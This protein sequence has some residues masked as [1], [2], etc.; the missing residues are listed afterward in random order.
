[1]N[2]R[3]AGGN[4]DVRD[5]AAL[6]VEQGYTVEPNKG[7]HLTVRDKEGNY[8]T[9][10]PNSPSDR[11][12]RKNALGLFR[13]TVRERGP[14]EDKED[15]NTMQG[16]KTGLEIPQRQV[17]LSSR[18]FGALKE[19]GWPTTMNARGEFIAEA[20]R[21]ARDMFGV[22][23]SPWGSEGSAQSALTDLLSGKRIVSERGLD[24][25]DYITTA[26]PEETA[27]V[28][29]KQKPRGVAATGRVIEY[30][31]K[32]MLERAIPLTKA[33][34]AE[35]DGRNEAGVRKGH[36]MQFGT[37]KYAA[38]WADRTC[39]RTG[40]QP[41]TQNSK[42][43][44]EE[45]NS[46]TTRL[47]D[48]AY[49]SGQPENMTQRVVEDVLHVV[50]A[51]A[52]ASNQEKW[53]YINDP[54]MMNRH[55]ISAPEGV[56]QVDPKPVFD[57]QPNGQNQ[58]NELTDEKLRDAIAE[59]DLDEEEVLALLQDVEPVMDDWQ[60]TEE[61]VHTPHVTP[62]HMRVLYAIVAGAER[63]EA[64]DL[65]EEIRKLEER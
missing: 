24:V 42:A 41:Y 47:R 65:A 45:I 4:R 32:E 13:R 17:E 12:W 56:R 35:I 50:E 1:M 64:L 19:R 59:A 11:R 21:T 22:E 26:Q 40:Y 18:V 46:W 60:Y 30:A 29:E 5:I 48:L 53:Q 57:K 14:Q 44:H 49:E 7:G 37:M 38:V 23:G 61:R 31:P 2:T 55:R 20:M 36:K 10:L 33:M 16:T 25:F 3:I 28:V 62:L 6:W 15:K 27:T 58:K 51:W 43:N 34:I 52:K 39:K 54:R 8:V 9:S 63:A